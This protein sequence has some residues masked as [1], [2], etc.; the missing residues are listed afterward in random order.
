M[1]RFMAFSTVCMPHRIRSVV[2]AAPPTHGPDASV[3]GGHLTIDKHNALVQVGDYFASV[4][5]IFGLNTVCNANSA[6]HDQN[7]DGTLSDDEIGDAVDC[8]TLL[9][10]P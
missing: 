8:G 4:A 9:E 7:V 3:I 2:M 10:T 5:A 6:F 1:Q